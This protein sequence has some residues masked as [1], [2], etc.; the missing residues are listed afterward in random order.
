MWEL[1]QSNQRKTFLLVSAMALV[2]VALGFVIGEAFAP[3]GGIFGLAIAL[4]VWGTM[5]LVS[6]FQ[7][8]NI[9]LAVSGAAK[10]DREDH[11]QLFNV[12][13][14]MTI[15]SGKGKIPD[16][17]V[18]NDSALNAFATGR[19]PGHAA[20]AVTSG[21]LSALDRDELQGVIAH[22]MSH[23]KNRDVLLMTMLGIMLGAIVFIAEVYLRSLR[24]VGSGSRRYSGGKG[25]G[26]AQ[27]VMM[28][29]AVVFAL[30][31]PLM[32]QLIYFAVSRR[33]EYLA[34]AGAAVMTRYPEGLASALERISGGNPLPEKVSRATAPM[35]I[36]DPYG[37]RALSGLTSTHPPIGERIKILRTM[38]NAVSYATYQQA[39]CATKQK[40]RVPMPPSALHEDTVVAARGPNP[41]ETPAL[42]GGLGGQ[43]NLVR[44]GL[45]D[46]GDLVRKAAG[47]TFLRCTCGMQIKLPPGYRG[48][49][50]ECPR[51]QG[52]VSV[53]K[54]F[55]ESGPASG[56][57]EIS[58]RLQPD[59]WRTF[60]CACG[61]PKTVSPSFKSDRTLC[62]A[63]GRAIR[64][65]PMEG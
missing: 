52:V 12:V 28:V 26:Q 65:L 16:I 49:S 9:L 3:G 33:R 36:A 18:M 31:A 7:G 25:G 38:G 58:V 17:Y 27:I 63:C 55:T 51:C 15:A 11:P 64:I 10:I 21:L 59:G 24:R 48:P 23:I 1:I 4:G 46:T 35:F 61:T 5:S 45:R 2:L 29:V 6:Y 37:S 56:G 57:G 13:E 47:F 22:E 32:A 40:R 14:E 60:R 54:A 44:M 39:W 43:G 34:D 62:S 8:D 53:P 41:G 50:I 19:D 20:V 30:L 42:R